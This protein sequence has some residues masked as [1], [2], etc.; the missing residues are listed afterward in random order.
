MSRIP[1]HGLQRGK[2]TELDFEKTASTPRSHGAASS[3]Q[4]AHADRR[5]T[6]RA[7]PHRKRTKKTRKEV[8]A[9]LARRRAARADHISLILGKMPMELGSF[10]CV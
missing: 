3:T 7:A 6:A 1:L 10:L 5:A 8:A 4:G 2:D 9:R